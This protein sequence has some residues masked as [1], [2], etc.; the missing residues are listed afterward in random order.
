[1]SR[2][3]IAVVYFWLAVGP[4]E[5]V[6]LDAAATH[7]KATAIEIHRRSGIDLIFEL[8]G[9][10]AQGTVRRER[11]T[12]LAATG[13]QVRARRAGQS[14]IHISNNRMSGVRPKVRMSRAPDFR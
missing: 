13:S 6:Q 1:M 3:S 11:E 9:Q 12:G 10:I 8:W 7:E 5:A 4:V 14:P 2:E